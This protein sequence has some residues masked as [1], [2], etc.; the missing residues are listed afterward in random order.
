MKRRRI[1]RK[2]RSLMRYAAALKIYTGPIAP[3][4][5]EHIAQEVGSWTARLRPPPAEVKWWRR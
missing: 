2:V 5:R 1:R 4:W 3:G